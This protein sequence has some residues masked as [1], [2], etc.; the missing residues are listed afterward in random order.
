[1][2]KDTPKV[3]D[4]WERV[5]QRITILDIY[6]DMCCC[7]VSNTENFIQWLHKDSFLFMTYLGHSKAKIDDLFKTENE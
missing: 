7:A 5:H 3:G 2:S 4:V 6:N 1:M